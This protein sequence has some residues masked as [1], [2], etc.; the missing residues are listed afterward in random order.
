MRKKL[1]SAHIFKPYEEYVSEAIVTS[2]IT[3]ALGLVLGG[4]I[5]IIIVTWVYIPSLVVYD[6]GLAEFLRIFTPYKEIIAL[7]V[8]STL[9]FILVGGMTYSIFMIYPSFK[10]SIRKVNIDTQLPHAVMYMYALSRGETNIIEIIRSVATLP[11][12]Y[13][14]VSKEFAKILRDMELLG[15]D[16]MTALRNLQ[17][18]TPSQN[19]SELLGN[20]ITLI[21]NGGEITD[22]FAM[23]IENSR[24]KTKSEHGLFLDMLGMIAEGYVTGFVAGPLF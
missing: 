8:I 18:E 3:A 17:N 16:F 12:V 11:N 7:S 6:P 1:R 23:Q 20:L 13:G 21:D 10:S 22:F 4:I 5:G 15:I 24:V 19:L 9:F 14:E 2:L